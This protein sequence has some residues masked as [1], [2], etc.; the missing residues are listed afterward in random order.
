MKKQQGD[1]S[2]RAHNI[3][4]AVNVDDVFMERLV[5]AYENKN[6][7]T[8][9]LFDP[10]DV[11][12]LLD[13]YGEEFKERYE[14]H[15]N[16]FQE[17]PSIYNPN[18]KVVKVIEIARWLISAQSDNGFPYVTYIDTV[19]KG[20]PHPEFGKI[21][22][23]NLCQ[24][25]MLPADDYQIAVCNLGSINLARI[26]MDFDLLAKASKVLSRF[27]DN[28]IDTT[29]YPHENA[30]RTQKLY[31]ANG[32]GVMGEAELIALNQIHFGSEEHLELIDKIYSTIDKATRE[33]SKE[34]AALKGS[35]GAEGERNAYRMCIAPNTSTGL[36][37]STTSGCEPVY[38]RSWVESKG[39]VPS[40][41]MTAPGLTL[42]NWE[43]YLDAFNI[44]QK[45]MIN[46]TSR[47]QKYIDMSISHSFFY[48]TSKMNG[49]NLLELY[50]HAWKMKLK[51]VYYVRSKVDRNENLEDVKIQCSACAN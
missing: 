43:Y 11:P 27:L 33:S 51:S 12:E 6:P 5:D 24:E 3:S 4:P 20:N 38:G 22:T 29:T 40:I 32:V 45:A 18:T 16:R 1:V 8:Y 25:V 46:A 47:R 15:E 41:P 23:G 30:E 49:A 36:F 34:L 21:R 14:Y 28:S 9:T 48:D 39:Q 19:N 2:M 31:R 50:I 7:R 17:D 26:G 42:D 13:L 35:C 10:Y 44:D 37:A